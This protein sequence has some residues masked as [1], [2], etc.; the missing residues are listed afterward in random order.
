MLATPARAVTADEENWAAEAKWDGARILA[1]ADHSLP[2][3]QLGCRTATLLRA[4]QLGR[5][6]RHRAVQ[7]RCG[8]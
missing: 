8:G 7:R 5:D 6:F 4:R 2:V 3:G 1:T